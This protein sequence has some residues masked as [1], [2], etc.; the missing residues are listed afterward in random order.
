MV[1]EGERLEYNWKTN[2]SQIYFDFHGEPKGDTTGFYES[3][4]IST[5]REVQGSLKAP[6]TGIHGWYWKNKSDH[7]IVINLETSGHY[8]I[9]GLK[10]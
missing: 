9:S 6:F 2:E 8:E 3:F 1:N 5:A 7:D 4:T 10:K